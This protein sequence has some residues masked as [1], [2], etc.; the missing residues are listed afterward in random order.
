MIIRTPRPV[1]V[2]KGMKMIKAEGLDVQTKSGNLLEILKDS[3]NCL[4]MRILGCM[5][6]LADFAN[7]KSNIKSHE[8]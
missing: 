6:E 2:S 4:P 7:S 3:L 1:G 8:K 5:H